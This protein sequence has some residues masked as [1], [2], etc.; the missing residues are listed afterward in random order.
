MATCEYSSICG[1]DA[2]EEHDGRCILHSEEISKDKEAFIKALKEHQEAH[3]PDFRDMMFPSEAN[4]EGTTFEKEVDF[5]KATFRKEATFRKA[6]F[7]H[8]SCFKESCFEGRVDFRG[9]KFKDEVSFENVKIRLNADFNAVCFKEMAL[10][11]GATFENIEFDEATFEEHADFKNATFFGNADIRDV[12]FK[13]GAIFRN[14]DFK[15]QLRF[16][17]STFE[18]AADF[19]NI[20]CYSEVHLRN[21]SFN[22]RS[23]LAKAVFKR[24]AYFT[25]SDFKNDTFWRGATFKKGA[26]FSDVDFEGKVGFQRVVFEDEAYFQKAR[27]CSIASFRNCTFREQALFSGEGESNRIFAGAEVDFSSVTYNP[28]LP[29]LFRYSDLSQCYFIKTEVQK[30]DFTGAQW[31]K[32]VSYDEW[33]T[34]S[35]LYDEIASAPNEPLQNQTQSE[36]PSQRYFKKRPWGGGSQAEVERLYRQLKKNYED[37]GDFPRAGDFH[38]GEKE[39]RRRN[40]IT[41]WGMSLLL[42]IYRALSKYGERA[43]PAF[44]CLFGL[45]LVSATGYYSLMDVL[46]NNPHSTMTPLGALRLSLEATFFPLRPLGLNDGVVWMINL[47]QRLFAPLLLGLLALAIRQRVKR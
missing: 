24:S 7:Q 37:R 28:S 5:G 35:G 39:A 45:I 3:G 16:Y 36:K 2:L 42:F 9:A 33:F 31:C 32:E 1:R 18:G 41:S 43:T 38:I 25:S 29:P 22:G 27:F 8:K 19:R 21:V 34:R 13:T 30:I 12:T 11:E 15:N 47:L 14:A 17:K 44:L 46:P 40:P 10:F 6:V 4:F 26:Y 23:L 20:T